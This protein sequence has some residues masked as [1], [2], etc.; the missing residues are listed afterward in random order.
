MVVIGKNVHKDKHLRMVDKKVVSHSVIVQE[1][2]KDIE[3]GD[4]MDMVVEGVHNYDIHH[5][6][7]LVGM[8][9]VGCIHC[10]VEEIDV[11]KKVVAHTHN[12]P[13]SL[14]NSSLDVHHN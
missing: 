6:I 13:P 5:H 8:H 9:R 2:H 11:M 10:R 7:Y 12:T 4:H 3:D 14:D 1:A